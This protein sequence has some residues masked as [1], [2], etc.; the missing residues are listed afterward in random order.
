MSLYLSSAFVS[1]A[2]MSR[3]QQNFIRSEKNDYCKNMEIIVPREALLYACTLLG[4]LATFYIH[5]MTQFFPHSSPVLGWLDFAE[6]HLLCFSLYVERTDDL[7]RQSREGDCDIAA[8]ITKF[9]L[10]V[11]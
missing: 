11:R 6:W 5:A 2:D 7:L 10:L 3:V 1:W 4:P 8:A 9:Q